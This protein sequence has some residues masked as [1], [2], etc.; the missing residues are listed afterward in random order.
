MFNLYQYEKLLYRNE[1]EKSPV[2]G[3]RQL[4]KA[5]L[6]PDNN[7]VHFSQLKKSFIN[8]NKTPCMLPSNI[9][10]T[11]D[12]AYLFKIGTMFS[13]ISKVP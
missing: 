3:R 2:M 5:L 6:V 9:E 10:F 7:L 4:W 12:L 13:A 11:S 1:G 8:Q